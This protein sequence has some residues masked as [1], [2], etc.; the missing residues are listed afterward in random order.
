MLSL[1]VAPLGK[2]AYYVAGLFSCRGVARFCLTYLLPVLTINEGGSLTYTVSEASTRVSNATLLRTL[3][4]NW[5][6][7]VFEASE[8]AVRVKTFK[9]VTLALIVETFE[10]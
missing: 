7:Y 6:L 5:P 1:I 8:L 3:E 2:P 4:R 9:N 10:M